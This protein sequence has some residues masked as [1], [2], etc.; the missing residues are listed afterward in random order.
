MNLKSFPLTTFLTSVAKLSQLPA[1]M[2]SEIAF[3][4]RSN[5]GKSSAINAITG[6]KGLAKTSKTPGRTQLLNFFMLDE[7]HRLVDL[8]GYGYAKVTERIK[9]R[10]QELLEEYFT[11]RTSLVCLV[12]VMD[13]RH[14]L[15]EFDQQML[16][17]ANHYQ[18][19]IHILLTKADKLS[20]SAAA[21]T[22]QQVK[23][24][25][26]DFTAPISVQLFS[27]PKGTGVTEARKFLLTKLF[28]A[29][30]NNNH[31]IA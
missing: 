2:G 13:A 20:P 15:K 18:L 19:P 28:D 16:Q 11:H 7:Q 17:W 21:Q 9:L 4:G 24:T 22:L 27:A 5:A 10:W 26:T 30:N 29:H 31:E 23:K 6:V 1:D 8:P 25:L 12:L 14:P 3:A